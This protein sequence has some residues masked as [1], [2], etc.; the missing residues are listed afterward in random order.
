MIELELD[1]AVQKLRSEL[2]LGQPDAALVIFNQK[3]ESQM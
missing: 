1:R 3:L 2:N